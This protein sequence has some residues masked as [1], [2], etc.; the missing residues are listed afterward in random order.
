MRASSL[1]RIRRGM[2]RRASYE[3]P[4]SSKRCATLFSVVCRSGDVA[5]GLNAKKT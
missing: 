2:L 3:A 1:R 5:A 4:E